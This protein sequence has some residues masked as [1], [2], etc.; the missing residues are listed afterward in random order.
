MTHPTTDLGPKRAQGLALPRWLVMAAAAGVTAACGGYDETDFESDV[1][2]TAQACSKD[3]APV[4]KID[5]GKLKGMIVGETAEFLGIPYARPPVGELR[6][7]PPQPVDRWKGIRDATAFGLGCPQDSLLLGPL[8]A[9]EDCLTLNV[10]TPRDAKKSDRL[11]V[12]VFIHGGAFVGGATYQYDLQSLSEAGHVVLV[13][14]NYRLGALGFFSHPALDAMRPAESPS[15]N[16]G[17]RDQQLAL[18]WVRRNIRA[19]GGSAS[20]VTLF[21]ESAGS[22]STCLHRVSPTSRN[23][24]RRFIME[25]GVCVGGLP[26]LDKAGANA[27]SAALGEAFCPGASDVIDCLRGQNADELAAWGKELGIS[28]PGWAPSYDPDDPLMP[29]SPAQLIADGNFNHGPTIVGSNRDEWG[30]FQMGTGP[31]QTAAEFEAVVDAQFGPIAA[32]VKSQYPVSG[33]AEANPVY[34]RLMTDVMF[35]CSTRTLARASTS[36]GS[37][38]YLY[39]FEEGMA[40]HAFEMSYVFGPQFGFEPTYVESTQTTMQSYWTNFAA[41]GTP[42]APSLPAW[43]LYDPVGDQHMILRTP[44]EVGSGLAQSDCDFW[45][46]LAG[47]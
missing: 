18:D 6:F 39:S 19:F 11:P 43:P 47:S 33:D 1:A 16:D 4:V 28:G 42:N 29:A 30:L 17:I 36:Q 23:F 38:V 15:G 40:F 31:I 27:V 44:F 45:D 14:M 9:D 24:A 21:G 8:P 26:L 46:A 10:F 2:S 41:S 7:A 25:S 20:K 35:R 32:L 22:M 12:M 34:I 5:A 3:R 13:S 37:S